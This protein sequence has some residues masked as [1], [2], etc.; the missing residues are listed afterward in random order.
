M[1]NF[2]QTDKPKKGKKANKMASTEHSLF[3]PSPK[4]SSFSPEMRF[5]QNTF[6][7]PT[8]LVVQYMRPEI[9][10]STPGR[11]SLTIMDKESLRHPE[12]LHATAH[13]YPITDPKNFASGATQNEIV[14]GKNFMQLGWDSCVLL[15]KES[16]NKYHLAGLWQMQESEIPGDK[17]PKDVKVELSYKGQK[18][19]KMGLAFQTVDSII[20]WGVSSCEVVI[21]VSVDKKYVAAM[22]INENASLP[23]RVLNGINW[24][25][26][27][28]SLIDE[29]QEIKRTNTLLS[30]LKP[31]TVRIL[32]RGNINDDSIN[33]H[34]YIGIDLSVQDIFRIFGD[35]GQPNKNLVNLILGFH[36]WA[37]TEPL[38]ANYGRLKQCCEHCLLNMR[39]PDAPGEL[40]LE[41]RFSAMKSNPMLRQNFINVIHEF[42]R[43][44]SFNMD[45]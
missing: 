22:H 8:A 23:Y 45:I 16:D 6:A 31:S 44:Q 5:T 10:P 34:N 29:E 11:Q 41:E 25:S 32:D 40:T 37:E 15:H 43:I 21:L 39:F 24:G 27:F 42:N 19:G 35:Q 17:Q 7:F 1:Y 4:S 20:T 26:A 3:H 14:A 12:I 13:R 18:Q 33:G 9:F 28:I 2:L 38:Y 36:T 30:E